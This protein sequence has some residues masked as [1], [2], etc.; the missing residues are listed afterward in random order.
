MLKDIITKILSYKEDP[1]I[2]IG[3]DSISEDIVKKSLIELFPNSNKDIVNAIICN[4]K[5]DI[6]QEIRDIKINFLL[7]E[8]SRK[9]ALV[10]NILDITEVDTITFSKT[11]QK[12]VDKIIHANLSFKL[13]VLLLTSTYRSFSE[14][15]SQ[16]TIKGGSGLLYRADLALSII[17]KEIKIIKNRYE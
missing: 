3:Y 2:L 11:A 12:S 9:T 15:E 1:I 10:F 7:D 14:K 4:N 5:N 8:K 17:R 13:P 6:T 16:Y